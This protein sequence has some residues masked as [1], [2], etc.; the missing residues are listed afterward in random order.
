MKLFFFL[1]LC[2]GLLSAQSGRGKAQK[3]YNKKLERKRRKGVPVS[4]EEIKDLERR[5]NLAPRAEFP[6]P[7][8]SI[9][10]LE[11]EEKA[12]QVLENIPDEFKKFVQTEKNRV[13]TAGNTAA[14]PDKLQ[15]CFTCSGFFKQ[16]KSY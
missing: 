8:S 1:A 3:K 9:E 11:F 10:E 2:V 13:S 7:E 12:K 5:F 4:A 6:A 15:H 16:G 14:N